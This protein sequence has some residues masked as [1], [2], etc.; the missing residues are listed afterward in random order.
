MKFEYR[1]LPAVWPTGKRTP[2]SEGR[3]SPFRAS[4]SDTLRL[5]SYELNQLEAREPIVAEAGYQGHEI[6]LD[7]LPRRGALP[8]DPAIILS[9]GSRFGPLRYGCDSYDE[10][11]AT[12][13]AIARSLEALRA[14]DRYGVSKRGEQYAGWLALPAAVDGFQGAEEAERF[15]REQAGGAGEALNLA[16]AYRRA[17]RKLHPDTSEHYD[18]EAWHRLLLAREMVKLPLRRG[19][20]HRPRELGIPA[21]VRAALGPAMSVLLLVGREMRL[22]MDPGAQKHGQLVRWVTENGWPGRCGAGCWH[23]TPHE[24]L[25]CWAGM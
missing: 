22:L 10:H 19:D 5:L 8:Q 1:P 17:A 16:T 18:R 4:Y 11:D 12:L 7:G 13:R 24:A 25:D 6:R 9:F 3:S 21:A 2:A 15:I 23:P 14:V 20:A